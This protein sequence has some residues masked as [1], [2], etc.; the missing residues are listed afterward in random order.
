MPFWCQ[1]QHENIGTTSGQVGPQVPSGL[2]YKDLTNFVDVSFA[3][4]LN[5]INMCAYLDMYL[6]YHLLWSLCKVLTELCLYNM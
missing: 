5:K 1:E 3:L 6:P 4:I 2:I